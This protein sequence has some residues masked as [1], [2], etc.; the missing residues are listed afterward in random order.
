VRNSVDQETK[1]G[2]SH[3]KM[4]VLLRLLRIKEALPSLDLANGGPLTPKL[5]LGSPSVA[6]EQDPMQIETPNMFWMKG[7]A[8]AVP[9]LGC[10]VLVLAWQMSS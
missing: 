1:E 7:A 2:K 10:L 3:G 5:P 8:M 4:D 9:T 6:T